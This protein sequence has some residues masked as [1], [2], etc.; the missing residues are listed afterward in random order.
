MK[1]PLF[2]A[3]ALCSILFCAACAKTTISD[4]VWQKPKLDIDESRRYWNDSLEYN[5]ENRIMY[6]FK[7]DSSNLYIT[8]RVLDND[9]Q[10]TILR[11]GMTVWID[12]SGRKKDRVGI[13][14]PLGFKNAPV[15]IQ[16]SARADLRKADP[17]EE[18]KNDHKRAQRYL[19]QMIEMELIGLSP[20][21]V[22]TL[23]KSQ[24]GISVRAFFDSAGVM[25]YHVIVPFKALQYKLHADVLGKKPHYISIGFETGKTENRLDASQGG[26]QPGAMGNGGMG[27]AGAGSMGARGGGGMGQ[28]QGQRMQNGGGMSEPKGVKFWANVKTSLK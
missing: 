4:S 7:N 21:P 2:K 9:V 1:H 5:A 13:N 23:I 15:G 24:I 22:R 26:S 12:T 3:L 6:G 8:M 27:G 10:K 18:R 28:A 20:E 14:Y 17:D 25:N 19:N 11:L 16:E